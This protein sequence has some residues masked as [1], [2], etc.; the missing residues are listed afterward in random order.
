MKKPTQMIRC[1]LAVRALSWAQKHLEDARLA[2]DPE[3]S[4]RHLAA[5]CMCYARPFTESNRIGRRSADTVPEPFREVHRK[6][7]QYRNEFAA[8][9][10]GDNRLDGIKVPELRPN[11]DQ[12]SDA[13]TRG[14]LPSVCNPL[15]LDKI[16]ALIAAV[17]AEMHRTAEQLFNEHIQPIRLPDG[18]DY[19]EPGDSWD[20]KPVED[21]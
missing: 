18:E 2:T 17:L 5:L 8:H 14:R 13:D 20:L 7:M 15:Y 4:T 1:V 3:N 21:P 6:V 16:A 19:L 9:S 12:E 11:R 10:D